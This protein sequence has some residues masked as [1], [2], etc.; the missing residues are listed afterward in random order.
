MNHKILAFVFVAGFFLCLPANSHE[1]SDTIEI[2]T[3]DGS[4]Q[5][6]RRREPSPEFKNL[7]NLS[8]WSKDSSNEHSNFVW[9]LEMLE[10][11]FDVERIH[12]NGT[13]EEKENLVELKIKIALIELGTIIAR[14]DSKTRV[15]TSKIG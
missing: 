2:Q 8:L 11:P 13:E 9:W 15:M 12:S 10:T 5:E 3:A 7:L 14:K 1:K 6:I 4:I